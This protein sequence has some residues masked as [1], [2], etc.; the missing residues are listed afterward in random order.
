M[1]AIV[2]ELNT[3]EINAAV[4]RLGNVRA[5]IVV[6]AM[7]EIGENLLASTKR[8]FETSTGPDGARWRPNTQLTYLRWVGDKKAYHTKAGK[9][10]RK[11]SDRVITKKPL[12]GL[13]HSL[14]RQIF[15]EVQPSGLVIG[16][17]MKYAAMQQFGGKTSPR[18]LFPNTKIPARPFLGFSTADVQMIGAV[19]ERRLRAAG[20]S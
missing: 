13:T 7:Q 9:L 2:F 19:V 6:A 8:R 20:F 11:G 14:S 17:S 10:N 15:W 5:N 4:S 16:S 12:I 18:S 3:Q 1:P